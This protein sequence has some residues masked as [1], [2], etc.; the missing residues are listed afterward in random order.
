M[1]GDSYYSYTEGSVETPPTSVSVAFIVFIFLIFPMST[2]A[3]TAYRT[4]GTVDHCTFSFEG[5]FYD[6]VCAAAKADEGNCDRVEVRYDTTEGCRGKGLYAKVD[7][8]EG[9]EVLRER[10]LALCPNVDRSDIPVCVDCLNAL[11]GPLDTLKRMGPHSGWDTTRRWPPTELPCISEFPS[12]SIMKCRNPHCPAL[13]CGDRCYARA[14]RS[15]HGA[16]CEATTGDDDCPVSAWRKQ[17]WYVAGIDHSDTFAILL[18]VLGTIAES[19]AYKAACAAAAAAAE[20]GA[21]VDAEAAA[22]ATA[23]ASHRR[24]AALYLAQAP[25]DVFVF[26]YLHEAHGTS[27]SDYG[28]VE[29]AVA[30]ATQLACAIFKPPASMRDAPAAFDGEAVPTDPTV[31]PT[32]CRKAQ[33][34]DGTLLDSHKWFTRSGVNLL[35]GAVLLNGQERAPNG[36]FHRWFTRL[37]TPD[38]RRMVKL[39]GLSDDRHPDNLYIARAQGIYSVHANSNHSCDPNT[40]VINAKS[41]KEHVMMEALRP[42]AAGDEICISYVDASRHVDSRRREL[43]EHYQFRCQCPKCVAEGGA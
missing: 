5:D 35:I 7:I 23:L 20:G 1:Y 22:V 40:T 16:I 34:L 21:G 30:Y 18:I 26:S 3:E 36:Y 19:P 9:G 10:A 13:F 39:L 15:W 14:M 12:P 6:A 2:E 37:P 24:P 4:G 25:F 38:Q 8:P 28:S 17:N 33:P 29:D 42:I 31:P 43:L 11:E 41:T 32:G 27:L